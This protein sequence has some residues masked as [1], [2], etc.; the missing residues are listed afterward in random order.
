MA[1][2]VLTQS[3]TGLTGV[4]FAQF[5]ALEA[6]RRMERSNWPRPQYAD[7]V[8]GRLV[9]WSHER[10]IESWEANRDRAAREGTDLHAMLERILLGQP[11]TVSAASCNAVPFS[12]GVLWWKSMLRRGFR[13]F[14]VEA[15]L[16]GGATVVE[17]DGT[18]YPRIA[19][20][21]D[22]LLTRIGDEEGVVHVVDHKRCKTDGAFFSSS[23]TTA[24]PYFD[25]RVPDCKLSKWRVQANIYAHIL[26]DYGLRVGSMMMVSHYVNDPMIDGTDEPCEGGM[27][28]ASKEWPLEFLDV[29]KLLETPPPGAPEGTEVRVHPR[30]T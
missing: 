6:C 19:G 16:W 27:A 10:I 5:D 26:S 21:C 24:A 17:P 25:E 29:S 13:L 15:I 14:A 2:H 9:P 1:G 8:D 4:P 3:V 23:R 30:L 7:M 18:E 28:L 22:L 20:S 11:V 12:M